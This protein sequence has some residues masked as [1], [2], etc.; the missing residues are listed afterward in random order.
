[1]GL[2]GATGAIG[3]VGVEIDACGAC[4]AVGV[5]WETEACGVALNAH[6]APIV[7][8]SGVFGVVILLFY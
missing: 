8:A 5:C 3:T 1:M 7:F 2:S 4:E 6:T